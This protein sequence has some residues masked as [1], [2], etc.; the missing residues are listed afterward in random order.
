MDTTLFFC[1][2][3]VMKYISLQNA[4]HKLKNELYQDLT[5]VIRLEENGKILNVF[6]ELVILTSNI[7]LLKAKLKGRKLVLFIVPQKTWW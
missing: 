3:R 1:R 5:S 4:L 2:V 7:F 6:N